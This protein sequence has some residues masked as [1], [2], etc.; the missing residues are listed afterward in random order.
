MTTAFDPW[1]T[2][3]SNPI[4]QQQALAEQVQRIVAVTRAL[5]E[6]GRRVDLSGLDG[7]VGLLCAKT[8]D[9]PP[10]QG[11]LARPQLAAILAELDQLGATLRADAPA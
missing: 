7:A 6:S 11:R 5:A 9:L 10:D 2:P 3:P 1:P 4:A 8:L